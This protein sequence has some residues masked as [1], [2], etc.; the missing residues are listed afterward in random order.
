MGV[1]AE[2]MK[3]QRALEAQGDSNEEGNGVRLALDASSDLDAQKAARISEL[4]KK[5]GLPEKLV[6]ENP[7]GA[8]Q[9]DA[10][11]R[12][13]KHP[14]LAKWTEKNPLTAAF[15]KAEPEVM[16][17]IFDF[18][19]NM[20]G[21]GFDAPVPEDVNFR[22][23]PGVAKSVA[24]TVARAPGIAGEAAYQGLA[25]G[26]GAANILEQGI[27]R[28]LAALGMPGAE[29]G[30][31]FGR[32]EE[33]ASQNADLIRKNYLESDLL[34]LS[35][36][37]RGSLWDH[38]EYL[39]NPEYLTFQLG[40]A[41]NSMAVML[42]AAG[43][44]RA[45]VKALAGVDFARVAAFFGGEMEAASLYN[46]LVKE[47]AGKDKALLNSAAFGMVTG[48]LN[49]LGLEKMFGGEAG[50]GLLSAL[51]R[52]FMAGATEAATEYAEEPAQAVFEGLAMGK[53][54]EE[55]LRGVF[56]SLKNVDVIP[57][58]LLLG[59]L[60]GGA[61]R[62]SDAARAGA[63]VEKHQA[64]HEKVEAANTKRLSPEHMQSAL[65]AA[66]PAMLERV[67]LP[68]DAALELYQSGTD[69]LT[70][71]GFTEEQAQGL[72]AQGQAFTVPVAKLHA[73]LDQQ[74][75]ESAA[76]IMRRNPEAMSA[77]EAAAIDERVAADA[78]KMVELYQEQA[79]E[80]DALGEAKERLRGETATAIAA[81]P[82]LKAQADS[83]AGGVDAYVGTWLNTIERYALRMGATGQSPL[84]TFQ[85]IAFTSLQQARPVEDVIGEDLG[86]I[87]PES[88]PET[89]K[90]GIPAK[91]G[92][93]VLTHNGVESLDDLYKIAAESLPGFQAGITSI[94]EATGG[95]PVFRPGDGLKGRKRAQEKIDR[96]Y[97]EIGAKRVLDV[98]GGTILYDS[99]AD[100][101]K[102]LPE[103]ERMVKE[104][105][106][107]IARQPK[108]RF[109]KPS[110][111]YKDYLLNIRQPNGLIT[112]LLLTTKAMNQAKT[113][114]PGHVLYEAMQKAEAVLK[115][116]GAA[117]EQIRE[118][119]ELF[120]QLREASEVY[121][122]S[123]GDQS[124][125]TASLSGIVEPLDRISAKGTDRSHSSLYGEVESLLG[126]IRNS[127]P[128]LANTYGTSSYSIN[129]LTNTGELGPSASQ[130][131]PTASRPSM[132]RA[133]N[134]L[135]DISEPPSNDSNITQTGAE[136]KGGRRISGAETVIEL[137]GNRS[138]PAR[139]ELWEM[140]DI[141]PSHD[142]EK[143]FAKRADYPENVQERPY[144]S[145]KGEQEKVT[146][147]ALNLKPH[148]VVNNNSD[149]TNGP[150]AVTTDGIVLGGNSR[151]MSIQLAYTK[152]PDKANAYREYIADQ[153]SIYGL[154]A[155]SVSGMERPVL[156]RVVEGGDTAEMGKL[157]RLYNQTMMQGL[158]SKAEGV[159]K[160]RLISRGT[161]DLLA[162]DMADFDS[163]REFLDA[164]ASRGFVEAL[165]KDGVLEQ[166]QISRLTEK[167]GRLNDA[168]KT[169]AENA[170][171]GMVVPD[172]DIL[173]AAPP[174]ALKKLDRVIPALARLKARGEG[175]DMS[176][177]V[178]A[179]LR[180]VGKAATARERVDVWLGQVDLIDA[181][182]D[183]RRPAVQALALTL[184]NAKVSFL[185]PM[186]PH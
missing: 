29:Q 32:L 78:Q 34:S 24:K 100:V 177:V 107:E 75:F 2:Y 176:G 59:F 185:T 49:R 53:A 184:E 63:F 57:G 120:E 134:G 87:Q 12:L 147:N 89:A 92:A 159:S 80:L 27:G 98:L 10:A 132:N 165:L 70:P 171:R 167:N 183:K 71:L 40:E 114:G 182:P 117:D 60:G 58:S 37:L 35:E 163:L 72:A 119:E 105:G 31:W 85:R 88:T 83:L 20:N 99:R 52:R 101:E 7:Y 46:D 33:L 13:E 15:A 137:G 144:H 149:L 45:G 17:G 22:W 154:D 186:H 106:G 55:I 104:A 135:A 103:I 166:T 113:E 160:A 148:L 26:A 142:P 151:A 73:Y 68:A 169:L 11:R 6:V 158:Q 111:G 66:G 162:K 14:L 124:N 143:Q 91:T 181:D 79:S 36:D 23:V 164:A 41:A 136:D 161:L 19:G 126:S 109:D 131:V 56:Q 16:A 25:L 82:G 50:Q 54:P 121:Y 138:Q 69:I 156:V 112:E 84:E 178:S 44:A 133:I 95:M 128:P 81:N 77:A 174:S 74:Q 86:V 157:A 48:A 145:D 65:E 152:H 67:D 62:R 127:L 21:Q 18:V 123:T 179:A 9:E 64:L 30:G 47:G 4:A 96:D 102:A 94:A 108:N 110:A 140:A 51:R 5:L 3:R 130:G 155:S 115:D 122:G 1:V 116:A 173:S 38:P 39:L 61:R 168:G 175:W 172:Y 170:L 153:A 42:G 93:A 43:T 97:P 118:A 90:R 76:Q 28:G 150:P 180:L 139:Y 141:I 146:G 129:S 125:A 8:W